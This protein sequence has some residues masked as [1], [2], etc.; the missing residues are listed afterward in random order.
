MRYSTVN[1]LQDI[2]SFLVNCFLSFPRLVKTVF[3]CLWY[4][5]QG[6]GFTPVCPS[7][8]T[9]NIPS[10]YT[11]EFDQDPSVKPHNK[12][13]PPYKTHDATVD[14][15]SLFVPLGND[16]QP[17]FDQEYPPLPS[18]S[19]SLNPIVMG[20]Y[21]NIAL[22]PTTLELKQPPSFNFTVLHSSTV[23]HSRLLCMSHHL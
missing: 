10:S 21:A 15:T 7:L 17:Q 18:E 5:E 6:Q 23:P 4:S 19:A 13:D 14:T 11:P 20:Q 12:N 9:E 3:C 16:L 8:R 1:L 2:L 22:S